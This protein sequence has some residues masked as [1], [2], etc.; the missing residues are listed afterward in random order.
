MKKG[1]IFDMD[2]LLFDTEKIFDDIWYQLSDQYH[3]E[4][5]RSFFDSNRGTTGTIMEKT[6]RQ[7]FPMHIVSDLIED[8]FR[9][10]RME[11]TEH[12]PMKKGVVEILKYFTTNDIKISI[13]SSSPKDMIINNLKISGIHS[14][15]GEIVSGDD[16]KQGKPSP[17]IFLLAA[18]RMGVD[19]RD[20]YVFED[21]IHGVH[22]GVN[23]G[24]TTIMI[25]DMLKPTQEILNMP[26][27][28]YKDLLQA[29]EAIE[30]K[31]L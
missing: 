18:K 21:G 20:C 16:V 6:I 26:V 9:R 11:L 14:Y 3:C 29:K 8:L 19:A 30:A 22:A 10:A 7:Y 23:A 5:D 4:L 24:C 1:A 31:K 12:V 25:P 17:E 13:A 28:I 27:H 2:G 15:I